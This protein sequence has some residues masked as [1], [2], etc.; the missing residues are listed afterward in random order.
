MDWF[1][2]QFA[3]KESFMKSIAGIET[4]N[5]NVTLTH[6]D[7]TP[8]AEYDYHDGMLKNGKGI[9]ITVAAEWTK[10]GEIPSGSEVKL[11]TSTTYTLGSGTWTVNGDATSYSGNITFYVGRE[12]SYTFNQQ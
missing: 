5:L 7:G 6:S 3:T 4:G 2:A 10:T 1:D 8:L 11:Q 12:G 9:T